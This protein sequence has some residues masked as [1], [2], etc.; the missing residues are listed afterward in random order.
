MPHS[1]QWGIF[2]ISILVFTGYFFLFPRI[3]SQEM[4]IHPV[5]VFDNNS[6]SVVLSGGHPETGIQFGQRAMY[7]DEKGNPVQ[8][9]EGESIAVDNHWWATE[10]DSTVEIREPDGRLRFKIQTPA[11]PYTRNGLLF[12]INSFKGIVWKVDPVD[13]EILWQREF[14]SEITFLDAHDT[15]TLIGLLD[16]HCVLIH[17]TGE[18]LHDFRPGGSRIEAIYGGALSEDGTKIALISG[19][20]PQQFIL[21]AEQKKEFHLITSHDTNT[22]FRRNVLVQFIN[23]SS[24]AVYES[25]GTIT[26][27]EVDGSGYRQLELPGT[28][29]AW[30]LIEEVDTLAILRSGPSKPELN[31][32]TYSEQSIF[33]A[34]LPEDIRSITARGNRVFL[35]GDQSISVFEVSIQ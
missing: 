20:D 30:A 12:L 26:I 23:D 9:L 29:T 6:S 21:L 33:K 25:S 5:G 22:D 10:Q 32:L 31:I 13:G 35:I 16:G 3:F 15:R 27:V 1:N 2:F 19:L 17:D 8:F 34:S 7:F 28:L 14:I 4:I 11:F 24:Q 18:I